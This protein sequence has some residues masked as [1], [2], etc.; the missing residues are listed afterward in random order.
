[1][2]TLDH[3]AQRLRCVTAHGVSL[4]QVALS[5]SAAQYLRLAKVAQKERQQCYGQFQSARTAAGPVGGNGRVAAAV[6]RRR[7]MRR[8]AWEHWRD[9]RERRVEQ[10]LRIL[11]QRLPCWRACA[12][13]SR[14]RLCVPGP[15]DHEAGDP[16]ACTAQQQR[17]THAAVARSL[18]VLW[19]A[20]RRSRGG[21]RMA[22]SVVH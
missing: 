9:P 17:G 21:G 8:A 7:R 15:A 16:A 3:A 13:S 6:T 19:C 10:S 1:M 12:R 5:C 18:L 11:T 14:V 4:D 20:G 22:P 2:C